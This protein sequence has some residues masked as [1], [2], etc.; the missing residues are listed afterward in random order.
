[1]DIGNQIKALRQRRGITQEAMAQHFGIT[2][3]AV[4]K[5]ERGVTTP[6]IALLPE[7]SA[8]FGV[9]IDELFS[10]SDETRIDRIQN[11]LWD[12]RFL[13][14]ADAENERQFL[15]EKARREPDNPDPHCMLAQL[16]LHLA[17]E[18]K[19]RAAEYAQ[20][21][22]ARDPAEPNVGFQ[23]LSKAMDGINTDPRFNLRCQL[24]AVYKDHVQ[25]YPRCPDAYPW[26][27]SQ[28]IADHRLEEAQRYCEAYS[29]CETG[30][31]VTVQKIKIA[32]ARQELEAARS[33]WEQLGADHPGDFNIWQWI[34]DFQT[35]TGH[36]AQAKE[37]YRRSIAL[38]ER[39]RYCDPVRALAL[40]CEM[41]GD[42][43]GAL[44]ARQLELAI[45]AEDW[46]STTGESV[47]AVRREI[48][49][50]SKYVTPDSQ[51]FGT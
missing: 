9:T 10:L 40:C 14:P 30:Y 43:A 8:Y 7:L 51:G 21:I 46:N 16:E 19:L 47:D 11:M 44:A 12:V 4:S 39:P 15:L 33:M 2:P 17:Q 24:I 18:H 29:K 48:E 5:W 23:Y 25:R 36:Y 45:C 13:N 49:R 37:S 3:Q 32:I 50:L 1:M 38:L 41:D 26:L 28:L 42:F 20:E 22:I 35:Q 27:I 34:G 31:S 6:D